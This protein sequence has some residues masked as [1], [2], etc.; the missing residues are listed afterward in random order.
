MKKFA[1]LAG[2]A[3]LAACGS[4]QEAATDAAASDAAAASTAATTAAVYAL[5]P[6]SYD[7]TAADGTKSVTTMLGDGGYVERDTNGKVTAKG[8]WANTDGKTCMTPEKGAEE[9][10]T[11]STPGADG[12]YTAT[13]S[14]GAVTQAKPHVK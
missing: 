5:A 2:F 11:L 8:K 7:S 10:Y 4:K 12:S 14:K 9:C 13:D 3:L 1:I 6:G